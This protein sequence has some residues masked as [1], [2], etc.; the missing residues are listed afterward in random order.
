MLEKYT[1]ND[2]LIKPKY[3]E[4]TSRK[5]V[6][7]STSLHNIRLKL[8]I[9]SANMK[10]VTGVEM[11]RA[12]ENNGG[13]GILHRFYPSRLEYKTEV[14][15]MSLLNKAVS[16]GVQE[17]DKRLFDE[18]FSAGARI[19][20]IDVAHGHHILVKNMINYINDSF[21]WTKK[22]A[23]EQT[24]II[25]GNIAT[26]DGYSALCDWG[27]DVVKVGIGGGAG[28]T[29]RKNTG[30]GYPQLSALEEI[31][32][33]ANSTQKR[34][35]IISDGGCS[36]VGDICKALKYSD[37]V[38]LG[39]MLAGFDESNGTVFI[40]SKTE[41]KYKV[42]AGSASAYS[43][44]TNKQPT[45]F[46][47]GVVS[48]IP[49]RGSVISQLKSIKEGIQSAFSYVGANNIEEYHSKCEFIRISPGAQKES[50]LI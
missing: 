23:K 22:D 8:P 40:D 50:K 4:I 47:E 21:K 32:H 20:C 44:S 5:N 18:L 42:Y 24:T 14:F 49:C 12:M 15:N 38:M 10:T 46:I 35:Q 27:A 13:L 30:V 41:Q 37:A 45:D 2:V 25:A 9:I 3:S 6:D 1:F 7:V 29:T 48:E 33:R 19:F 34:K 39:S 11:M 43:K 28:C 16:I 17:D 36:N 26:I 31:W